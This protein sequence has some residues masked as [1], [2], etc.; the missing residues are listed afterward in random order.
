MPQ[1]GEHVVH[2]P[3]RIGR[4]S[5]VFIVIDIFDPLQIPESFFGHRAPRLEHQAGEFGVR[6][7]ARWLSRVLLVTSDI[8]SLDAPLPTPVVED[9]AGL[10]L[11]LGPPGA[12]LSYITAL[13]DFAAHAMA[14]ERARPRNY[15]RVHGPFGHVH[16]VRPFEAVAA[17]G[18]SG[19]VEG[20]TRSSITCTACARLVL[21]FQ[22]HAVDPLVSVVLRPDE[23][24]LAKKADRPRP[25]APGAGAS[26][27]AP[28]PDA[29]EVLVVPA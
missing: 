5:Q 7:K 11:D 6:I 21:H 27:D 12:G 16:L 28:T 2:R 18:A 8:T 9:L 22:S 14:A 24:S 20:A 10:R 19:F 4:H 29:A 25:T 17:C 3:P 1:G 15:E 13:R 26:Q 23:V